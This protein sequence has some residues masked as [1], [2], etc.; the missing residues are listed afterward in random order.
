[1]KEVLCWIAQDCDLQGVFNSARTDFD[2]TC[3]PFRDQ[4]GL[5]SR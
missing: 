1:M 3:E 4:E 2:P 5:D